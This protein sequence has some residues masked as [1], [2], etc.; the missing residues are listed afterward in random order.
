M[1]EKR[2]QIELEV[3]ITVPL[4]MTKAML[5]KELRGLIS[6]EELWEHIRPPEGAYS[7]DNSVRLRKI[8]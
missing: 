3:S 5:V 1:T 7:Y 6:D 8:K 4:W 2:K